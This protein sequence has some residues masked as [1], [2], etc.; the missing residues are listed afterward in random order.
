MAGLEVCIMKAL[1]LLLRGFLLVLGTP[2][3]LLIGV[4]T[5]L[6]TIQAAVVLVLGWAYSGEWDQPNWPWRD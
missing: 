3:W 6:L 2:I 1:R 5:V 4:M